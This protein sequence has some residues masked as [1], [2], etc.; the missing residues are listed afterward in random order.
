MNELIFVSFWFK[1]G[2]QKRR[3]DILKEVYIKDTVTQ[4]KMV[5]LLELN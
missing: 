2:R 1:K 3:N 5:S 4:A